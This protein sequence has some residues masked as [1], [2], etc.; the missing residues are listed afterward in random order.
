MDPP[1][2]ACVVSLCA[3]PL[4][5]CNKPCISALDSFD[6]AC[7]RSVRSPDATIAKSEEGATPCADTIVVVMDA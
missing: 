2:G 6:K 5:D 1:D 7:K 3:L 4:H